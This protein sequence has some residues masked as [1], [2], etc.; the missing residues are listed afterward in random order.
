[1]SFLT[2]EKNIPSDGINICFV[3]NLFHN[4][5]SCASVH[6]RVAIYW[7]YHLYGITSLGL[8]N[9]LLMFAVPAL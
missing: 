4:Y 6:N 9:F 5:Q 2:F 8:S 1:M 3:H 7:L